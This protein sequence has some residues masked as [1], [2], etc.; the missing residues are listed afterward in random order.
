MNPL[1][2]FNEW[3]NEQKANPMTHP[4]YPFRA[5]ESRAI[6]AL[7]KMKASA[8]DI[9]RCRRSWKARRDFEFGEGWREVYNKQFEQWLK[10]TE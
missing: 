1:S 10:Q 2:A 6:N 5:E 4:T 8:D 7:L 3:N 9:E